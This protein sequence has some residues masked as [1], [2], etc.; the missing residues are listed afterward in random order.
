MATNE[1]QERCAPAVWLEP[2]E[3]YRR[4][5]HL[6]PF[7][8]DGMGAHPE[9]RHAY[10]ALGGRLDARITNDR[11]C[12]VHDDG[13]REEREGPGLELLQS[14]IGPWK[15]PA[16]GPGFRGGFVGYFAYEFL[17]AIEP[18]LRIHDGPGP[19]ACLRLCRDVLIFDRVEKTVQCIANDLPGESG[20]TQRLDAIKRALE[21]GAATV[22][23]EPMKHWTPSMDEE[24]FVQAVGALQDHIA[25]GDLFQANIATQFTTPA[26]NTP[27]ALFGALQATNPS[28]F[29]AL[30]DWGDHAIVSNSPEQL[31][32]V[33]DGIVRARPIA[34]TRR[35]GRTSDEDA[36]FEMELLA[37]A[38]E[39]AEHTMLVDLLRNDIAQVSTPGTTRVAELGSIERYQR[40]MHLVSRVEGALRPDT[41]FVDWLAAL[42]PGGTITGAPKHRA[43]QRIHDAEPV[44]RGAY[45]GSAGFLSWDQQ[46]THWSIMIRTMVLRDGLASVH[47]GSGIV[48]GSDPRREWQEAGH[49]AQSLVEVAQPGRPADRIGEVSAHN[50]WN[51]PQVPQNVSARVLVVDNYDSFVHNLADYC[52]VVG[53]DVRVIRNDADPDPVLAEFKPTHVILSPGPG[54]PSES[55]VTMDLAHRDLGLPVLGVCLGHQALAEAAGACVEVADQAVHGETDLVHHTGGLHEGLPSPFRATRYHSLVVR[56]ESVPDDWRVTAQLGDGTVMA[57]EHRTR[58]LFGLQ[59]HPESI[60]TPLGLDI[61]IRFLQRS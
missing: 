55:G 3:A 30:M 50:S 27:D 47:A 8:L 48:A 15:F 60:G 51:P 24:A 18:T 10:I 53:A 35:R 52:A 13:T 5:K 34:G 38:K 2:I 49:K 36:A 28:P 58:P 4:L 45:T 14:L 20:A 19:H 23:L 59:Y 44:A 31:F 32:A 6:N 17:H 26:T 43:C 41:Q 22:K 1:L 12:I 57:M 56:P 25:N 37:D 61:L 7:L 16:N 33:E 29:M 39:Q 11:L 21:T 40:V 46:T 54:W 9:A 42:F